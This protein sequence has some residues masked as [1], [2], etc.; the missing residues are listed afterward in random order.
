MTFQY[1]SPI[2]KAHEV[3]I[4][5][6]KQTQFCNLLRKEFNNKQL[7]QTQ[8]CNFVFRII[9]KKKNDRY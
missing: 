5:I 1:T 3:T 8:F 6:R 9:L 2:V 4:L 7:K